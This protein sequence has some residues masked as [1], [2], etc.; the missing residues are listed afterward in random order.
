MPRR[1]DREFFTLR[2]FAQHCG[3]APQQVFRWI[4]QGR[5]ELSRARKTEN[6]GQPRS[7]LWRIPRDTPKPDALVG[8]RPVLPK[9]VVK[10]RKAAKAAKAAT[11]TTRTTT[12]TD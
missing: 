10:Q 2:G 9:A 5:P 7:G 12:K 4:K 11:R 3:V 8:G 6:P 1:P